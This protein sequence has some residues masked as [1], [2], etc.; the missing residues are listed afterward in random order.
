MICYKAEASGKRSG[1]IKEAYNSF[2]VEH[3]EGRM[4]RRK[5][6]EMMTKGGLR[7]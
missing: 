4:K 3:P 1:D 7:K 5:F 2:I 6:R